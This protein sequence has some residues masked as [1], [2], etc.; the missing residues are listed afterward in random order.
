MGDVGLNIQSL[1][2]RQI[3]LICSTGGTRAEL[4]ELVDCLAKDLQIKV[5]KRLSLEDIKE[6]IQ[7]LSCEERS[8]RIL[9][10]IS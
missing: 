6:A 7:S 2:P 5:W 3:K 4:K 8:G 1:Y 9:L 10:E